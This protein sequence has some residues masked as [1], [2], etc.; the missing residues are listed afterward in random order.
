MTEPVGNRPWDPDP[1]YALG[2]AWIA[3]D[4][5]LDEQIGAMSLSQF[6][7]TN[8]SWMGDAALAMGLAFGNTLQPT[9]L[10]TVG[11]CWQMGESI[12]YY[13][14]LRTQQQANEMKHA[15]EELIAIALGFGVAFIFA[16]LGEI[17]GLIASIIARLPRLIASGS[18]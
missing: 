8:G 7:L 16:F 3:F 2:N 12:N 6:D 15:I 4:D 5:L 17:A 9:V 14:M 10:Q 18:A 13:A 1:V 11:L